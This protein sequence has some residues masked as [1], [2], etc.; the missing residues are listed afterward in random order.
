[1][2]GH[3]LQEQVE[4]IRQVLGY[5]QLFKGKTI[6]IKIDCSVMNHPHFP[7]LVKDL[8]LL[9]RQGIQIV[10]VPGAKE[11]IDEVLTRYHIDW[12]TVEGVRISTPEASAE[13]VYW[14]SQLQGVSGSLFDFD[15][16]IYSSW[17]TW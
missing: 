3:K 10:L 2:E 9:H 7:M 16:R 8:V 13:F 17:K 5:V 11:R 1:M 15:S 12:K 4:L 14:V 6:V